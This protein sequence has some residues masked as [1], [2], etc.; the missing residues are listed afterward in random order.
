MVT[1]DKHAIVSQ[2][3]SQLSHL[4]L[5]SEQSLKKSSQFSKALDDALKNYAT[6][7]Q[8]VVL[9]KDT[10]LAGRDITSEIMRE[11]AVQMRSNHE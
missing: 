9:N 6:T 4:K 3:V 8:A 11:V 1:F 7:R 2:F 5:S 10:V